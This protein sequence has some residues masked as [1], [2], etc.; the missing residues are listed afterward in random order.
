MRKKILWIC[1]AGFAIFTGSCGE[2][3]EFLK[4]P[5]HK[6]II[7][8]DSDPNWT[9]RIKEINNTSIFLALIKNKP[10]INNLNASSLIKNSVYSIDDVRN[11]RINFKLYTGEL[12]YWTGNGEYWVVFV[13]PDKRLEHISYVYASKQR[14][15][16]YAEE[17]RLTNV[18]FMPAVKTNIDLGGLLPF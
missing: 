12:N 11:N 5:P 14:H 17:T 16:F 18:D 2:M 4:Q 6:S 15:N 10:D 3:S 8:T 7:I 13:V 9:A 1:L